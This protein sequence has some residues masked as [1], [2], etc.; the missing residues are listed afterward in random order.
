MT[1]EQTHRKFLADQLEHAEWQG[2]HFYDMIF[3]LFVFI[4]GVS[5][6]FSL[7][8]IIRQEGR[9]AA[10]KRIVRRFVLLYVVA[11]IYSGGFSAA[12]P[13]NFG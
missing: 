8:K 7:T 10:L 6:V 1:K 9:A 12:W 13:D 3:P 5:I 2:F 4:M 11:L